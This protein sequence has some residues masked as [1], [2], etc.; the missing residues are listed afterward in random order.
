MVPT[1]T[2]SVVASKSGY[3]AVRESLTVHA[4]AT[5]EHTLVLSNTA[6]E[7]SR[8]HTRPLGGQTSPLTLAPMFWLDEH[9]LLIVRDVLWILFGVL[10]IVFTILG[11]AFPTEN[12]LLGI[13][14]G[15]FAFFAFHTHIIFGMI[16][17]V[18]TIV[19]AFAS[20]IAVAIIGFSG[21]LGPPDI[22][23]FPVMCSVW[24][25]FGFG[26]LMGYQPFSREDWSIPLAGLLI[27]V[28]TALVLF[29]VLAALLQRDAFSGDLG[30]IIGASIGIAVLGMA[31]GF[32]CAFLGH[33]LINDGALRDP[34]WGASDYKLP[35]VGE[36]YC[37][38]GN[39]G[40]F[41]HFRGGEE[42]YDFMA[43]E[44]TP[45]LAIKEGHIVMFRED[46]DNSD[47]A[48][49]MY[50][51]H[52]DGTIAE[53]KHF[54]H[55]GVSEY[56]RSI[57]QEATGSPEQRLD[58]PIHCHAGQRLAA[59]GKTGEKLIPHMHVAVLHPG[60]VPGQN[61]QAFKFEDPD[62]ARH[63]GVAYSMRKYRSANRDRGPVT[64]G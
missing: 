1:G 26:L 59:S 4:N 27:G 62:V 24:V 41:S 46:S 30:F 6:R 8:R 44:G 50:V 7:C 55:N 43:P 57:A 53:Y 39:R 58:D 33:L 36:R 42:A 9:W 54:R 19:L 63:G 47:E 17:G 18:T 28:L 64:L 2:V 31:M 21:L 52:R 37:L 49:V 16:P 5:T 29:L 3:R 13:A 10:T 20:F 56:C 23:A 45:I 34:T 51:R 40:W 22:V 15:C 61:F 14:A 38:Q 25:T 32:I 35:Y 12:A 48:N 60:P 11:I